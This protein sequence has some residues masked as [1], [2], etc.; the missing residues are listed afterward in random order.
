MRQKRI[1]IIEQITIAPGSMSGG[2]SNDAGLSWRVEGVINSRGALSAFSDRRTVWDLRRYL[3]GNWDEN[4]RLGG[5]V[6]R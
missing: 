2:R 5:L 4:C 6:G 3:P 1:K